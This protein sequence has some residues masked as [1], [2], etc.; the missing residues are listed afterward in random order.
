MPRLHN[1]DIENTPEDW[2]KWGQLVKYWIDNP[3]V[4][5]PNTVKKFN[6]LIQNPPWNINGKAWGPDDRAVNI[7]TYDSSDDT[8]TIVI[9]IPDKK[10]L[11]K[12]WEHLTTRWNQGHTKYPI[13][14]WYGQAFQ[15]DPPKRF[16][17]SLDEIKEM[18]LR[19]L[20]EYV[21]N[22]CM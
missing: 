1:V 3:G 14:R 10:M 22:E 21:I 12:D 9:P 2:L 8:K 20:G 4:V 7:L 5:R 16:F 6:D 11:D 17:N 15:N 18:G 19:R 13:P